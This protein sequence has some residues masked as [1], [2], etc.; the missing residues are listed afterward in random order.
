MIPTFFDPLYALISI[1]IILLSALLLWWFMARARTQHRRTWRPI[2]AFDA[3]KGLVGRM[4]EDGRRVHIA[5]GTGGVGDAQLPILLSG[6]A[7]LR[8]LARQGAP[9]GVAPL[10]TVA[11]PTTML[12]A[13][14]VVYD[15]YRRK[16][17]HKYYQPTDV[18]MIAPDATAYA[19]G[20]QSEVNQEA[21]AANVMLGHFEREYLL[22][23]E[24]G[25]QRGLVQLAGS[26]TVD[27][28]P[29]MLATAHNVLI[30][31]E[32]FAAG[33]YLTGEPRYTASLRVQDVLRVLIVLVILLGV[34][35][36]TLLG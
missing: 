31:E 9:L 32:A 26:D 10:V 23:G 30:G 18:Q 6:L 33:A 36:K 4:A 21:V 22:L 8:Y 27:A 2:P 7:V 34:L 24:A 29:F 13:Q 35:W 5:L 16:G 28:H 14:D 15:A 19:V 1:A 25:A 11:D 20:V 3:L 12:L 17:V